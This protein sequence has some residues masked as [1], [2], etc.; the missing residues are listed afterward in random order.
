MQLL[1]ATN[2]VFHTEKWPASQGSK[3][4]VYAWP[5]KAMVQVKHSLYRPGQ[6]LR[7]PG[8]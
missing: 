3:V 6:A 2:R 5:L 8:R 7:V 4:R 1:T